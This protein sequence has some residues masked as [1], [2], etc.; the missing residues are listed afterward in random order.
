MLESIQCYTGHPSIVALVN[1][2][3]YLIIYA[4]TP[5]TGQINQCKYY[6]LYQTVWHM[7][8]NK[9]YKKKMKKPKQS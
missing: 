1:H 3:L 4:T 2:H 9:N 5:T 8:N 6:S 7:Y